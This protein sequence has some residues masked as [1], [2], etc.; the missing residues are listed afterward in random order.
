MEKVSIYALIWL[1]T[2]WGAFDVMLACLSQTSTDSSIQQNH[3]TAMSMRL[4]LLLAPA[5][6]LDAEREL[7]VPDHIVVRQRE[8]VSHYADLVAYELLLVGPDANH[9]R[10]AS[11]E[12]SHSVGQRG[13]LNLEH[14]AVEVGI[15]FN[16]RHRHHHL[17]I[18]ANT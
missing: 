12:V 5:A 9:L 4:T 13:H 2:G 15:A 18:Q 16:V 14:L 8:V 11:L 3:S 7:H 17:T 6:F 10:Q 1:G